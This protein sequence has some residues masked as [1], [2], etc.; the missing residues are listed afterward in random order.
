MSGSGADTLFKWEK[1]SP[2][3][4]LDSVLLNLSQQCIHSNTYMDLRI[5]KSEIIFGIQKSK[6]YQICV[7]RSMKQCAIHFWRHSDSSHLYWFACLKPLQCHF[8]IWSFS[9]EVL[10]LVTL[11]SRMIIRRHLKDIFS[12][13]HTYWNC[14]MCGNKVY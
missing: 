14:V 5:A 3:P 13:K 6:S 10:D 4:V 7:V 9:L 1:G 11:H 12:F 2:V 8:R